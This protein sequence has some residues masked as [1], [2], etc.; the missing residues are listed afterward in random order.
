[1]EAGL[2][3]TKE[4][5]AKDTAQYKYDAADLSKAISSLANALTAL[6]DAKTPPGAAV[7]LTLRSSV[8]KGSQLARALDARLPKVQ[9]FLQAKVDPASPEYKYHSDGIIST[10]EDLHSEFTAKKTT[11]D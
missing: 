4:Q 8:E 5:L 10:I 2:A 6:K 7:L 3:A 11:L 1:M 9:A